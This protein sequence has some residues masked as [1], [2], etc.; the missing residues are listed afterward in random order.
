MLCIGKNISFCFGIPYQ[1][2][3]HYFL[4]A[5]HFHGKEVRSLFLF[6]QINFTKAPT[7]QHLNWD[8]VLWANLFLICCCGIRIT[9]STGHRLRLE[10]LRQLRSVIDL[11]C[12]NFRISVAIVC[13]LFIIKCVLIEWILYLSLLYVYILITKI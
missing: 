10:S 2:L 5:Q 6:H 1:V 3:P 13:T 11:L 9:I 7:T 12:H 8:K 4:F